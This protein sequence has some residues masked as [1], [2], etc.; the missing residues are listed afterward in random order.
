MKKNYFLLIFGLAAINT[1]IYSQQW[2]SFPTANSV[3]NYFVGDPGGNYIYFQE[4]TGDTIFN[5]VNYTAVKIREVFYSNTYYA[6]V[7]E[8]NKIVYQYYPMDSSE[9]V[10][11]N[12]N[13]DTGDVFCSPNTI[14]TL[15]VTYID[16]MQIDNGEYRKRL[17]LSHYFITDYWVEGVGSMNFPL[18]INWG[19]ETGGSLSCLYQDFQYLISSHCIYVGA[20]GHSL[21]ESSFVYPNPSGGELLIKPEEWKQFETLEIYNVTGEMVYSLSGNKKFEKIDISSFANGIY[22]VKLTG[23]DEIFQNKIIKK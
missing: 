5:N 11:F 10:I 7:R 1:S 9:L 8:A 4:I 17:W 22:I 16:S 23:E 2:V 14:D 13:L 12:F 6:Y 3:W 15:T 18:C 19:S 21:P 20:G